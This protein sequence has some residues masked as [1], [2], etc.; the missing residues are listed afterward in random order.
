MEFIDYLIVGQGLAGSLLALLLQERGRSV[1]VIDNAHRHAASKAA[2]G[3]INPITGK[4]LNRPALINEL[5]QEVFSIY[6]RIEAQLGQRLFEQRT[7]LRLLQNAEEM[8]RWTRQADLPEYREYL[9]DSPPK[10]FPLFRGKFGFFEVTRA[11]QLDIRSLILRAREFLLARQCLIDR[12]LRYSTLETFPDRIRWERFTARYAI[13][14]EG[15]RMARNPFFAEIELNPAKGET[16]TLAT[17]GFA[18]QRIV[19]HGKWIFRNVAGEILAGTNYRWDLLD[20]KPTEVAK[21]EI[22]EAIHEF[23]V[24]NFE[25]VEQ[26]AGV[27]PVIRADNRPVVGVHPRWPRL[28]ILNGLGSKGALQAPF[29]AQQL[30]A[31]LEE[32]KPVWK[33]ID[34]CRPS[35]WSSARRN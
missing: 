4:R 8:E 35:L 17:S 6:P 24:P 10:P 7:V 14:C 19:Q 9:S 26:R 3:I 15:Y 21:K 1:V 13:F 16:L 5:L 31:A 20:E 30:I 11:A 29:A 33:E 32:G 25:T 18:E 12:P 34:I 27:R 2:G 23:F 28:A 22:E